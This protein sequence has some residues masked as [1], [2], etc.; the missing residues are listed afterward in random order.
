MTC[1][2]SG[3]RSHRGQY[4]DSGSGIF[5]IRLFSGPAVGGG[6]VPDD[7]LDAPLGLAC[8]AAL[9]GG[10]SQ[11]RGGEKSESASAISFVSG[12]AFESCSC[13]QN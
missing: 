8:L 7:D 2:S 10:L 4:F 1:P 11:E 9:C 3:V 12:G 13:E 5:L 6:I